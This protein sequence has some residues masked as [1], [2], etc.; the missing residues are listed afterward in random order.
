MLKSIGKMRN[1]TC[2]IPYVSVVLM[3][4]LTYLISDIVSDVVV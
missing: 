4:K 1:Y 2:Y 3:V